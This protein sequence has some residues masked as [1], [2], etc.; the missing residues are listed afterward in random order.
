MYIYTSI[1]TSVYML[2][3]GLCN[4]GS[5]YV[6]F[7]Q[8]TD[9]RIDSQFR[10]LSFSRLMNPEMLHAFF[11]QRCDYKQKVSIDVGMQCTDLKAT[12]CKSDCHECV[13][14]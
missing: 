4:A 1:H 12:C 13:Q 10:F 3:A 5:F 14:R 2:T 6:I 7:A 9:Q 8:R 11:N